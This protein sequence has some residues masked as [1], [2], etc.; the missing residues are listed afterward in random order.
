MNVSDKAAKDSFAW[1]KTTDLGYA[2]L[3]NKT[4]VEDSLFGILAMTEGRVKPASA[5]ISLNAIPT[6]AR[7]GFLIAPERFLKKLVLPGIHTMFPGSTDKD[8]SLT[9]GGTQIVNVNTVNM[10]SVSISGSDY[11]PTLGPNTVQLAM[12]SNYLDFN[13]KK[14]VVLF[15]PGIEIHMN[16]EAFTD[17]R[18]ATQTGGAHTFEYYDIPNRQPIIDHYVETAAW[19]TWTEVAASVAVAVAT[20]GTG[21]LAKKVI[22]KVTYRVVATIITLLVGELIANIGG[23]I[24]AVAE[25][26]KDALPPV[27]LVIKNATDTVDWPGAT[28]VI[29]TSAGINGAFQLGVDPQFIH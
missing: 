18:L 14:A 17:L 1:L 22:E 9:N 3:N 6:G 5:Q 24:I 8:F 15:S 20:M 26:N 29:L 11:T 16:Y 10:D 12:E 28:D 27:D 4:N 23:I 19:V 25:G 7:A 21:A 2:C 13:L